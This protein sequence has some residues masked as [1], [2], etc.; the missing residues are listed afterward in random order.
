MNLHVA[1]EFPLQQMNGSG[2][3]GEI[4]HCTRLLLV[5]E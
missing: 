4:D 5:G 3:I 1:V 2:F